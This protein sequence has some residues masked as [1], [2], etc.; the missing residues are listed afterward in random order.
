MDI[1]TGG[2]ALRN[3]PDLGTAIDEISRVL[4]PCGVAAFLD[5][6]KPSGKILQKMEYWALKTWTGPWGTLLHR[7]REVYRYIAESLQPFPDR[8][9]LR[10]IFRDK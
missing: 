4:K 5:F 3:A 2:Y 10:D 9:Q 8:S 6:S 7:N 1:V